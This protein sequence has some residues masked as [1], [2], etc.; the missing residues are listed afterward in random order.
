[1]AAQGMYERAAELAP[2]RKAKDRHQYKAKHHSALVDLHANKE[3]GGISLNYEGQPRDRLGRWTIGDAIEA[4]DNAYATSKDAAKASAKLSREQSLTRS[5]SE[6]HTMAA[7][8]HETAA[9][10]HEKAA[11][12]FAGF[13][14]HW[15]E[16]LA[17]DSK[18]VSTDHLAK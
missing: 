9:N 10:T 13:D 11:K 2:N 6:K 4:S 17:S 15:I 18:A 5:D 14:N 1:M 12:M 7:S 3:K 16:E 8:A